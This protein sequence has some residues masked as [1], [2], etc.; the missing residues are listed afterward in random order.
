MKIVVA[1]N[2]YK[3]AGGEDQCVAAEVAMLRAYGHEVTEYYLHNDSID[4]MGHL[5]LAS[6]MIWSQPTVRELRQI[7]RAR[8][9]QIVHFHN[10]LPLIS[11]AAYY[12]ARAEDARVIQSLHNFRLCCPNA[13]LFRNGTVCEDCLGKAI[14][15]RGIAHKCYRDSYAASAAVAAMLTVHRSLGTWHD[16]I[17]TYIAL[18]EFGRRKFVEGGLPADKIAVKCNFAYPDPGPG[19]GKGGYAIYVGR[20]SKEKGLGTLLE[21][22]RHVGAAMPLKLVGDGPM[23]TTVKEA[24]AANGAIQWLGRMALG[25]VYN[26][27]GDAAVLVLPSQCY[28]TFARV[29][30]EAFAKGTPVIASRL[31][32]MPEIIDEGRTGLLFR[33]GDPHDLAAQIRSILADPVKLQRMRQGARRTFDQNFTADANHRSLMKIYH[34][35]MDAHSRPALEG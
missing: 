8:R 3:L 17:D 5:Q 28:E 12:V 34:R 33:P 29:I 25:A 10:T 31:G 4:G 27:I 6:R 11:P 13:L 20:L 32:A 16:A 21:A 23:A 22:W 15:W 1:H 30:I 14:P 24:A 19:E 35:A 7:L 18:T 26:L 9:P 2:F